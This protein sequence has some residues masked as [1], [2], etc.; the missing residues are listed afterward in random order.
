MQTAGTHSQRRVEGAEEVVLALAR[1]SGSSISSRVSTVSAWKL[2]DQVQCNCPCRVNDAE[3]GQKLA[4]WPSA[5]GRRSA[6]PRLRHFEGGAS[7]TVC[8]QA[9]WL[10]WNGVG[11]TFG[12]RKHLLPCVWLYSSNICP[13]SGALFKSIIYYEGPGKALLNGFFF[14][15]I[16]SSRPLPATRLYQLDLIIMA[17]Q[18]LHVYDSAFN[19]YL[20]HSGDTY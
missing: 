6:I 15:S 13:G 3:C 8:A 4:G 14:F 12:V 9:H 19:V 1:V 10:A 5:W 11:A 17:N 7:R 2:G 18:W 16:G 20:P